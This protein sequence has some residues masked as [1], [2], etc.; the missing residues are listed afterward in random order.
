MEAQFNPQLNVNLAGLPTR[1]YKMNGVNITLEKGAFLV[2]DKIYE[3]SDGLIT[4]L[5]NPDVFYGGIEEDENK[6][7]RI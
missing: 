3:F 2:K 6:N 5:T 1:R 7:K 4:F